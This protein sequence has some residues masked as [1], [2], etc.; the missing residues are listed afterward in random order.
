MQAPAF[1][2]RTCAEGFSAQHEVIPQYQEFVTQQ[3]AEFSVQ[4]CAEVPSQPEFS[5][6][7]C[8]EISS[9]REPP[10]A[11]LLFAEFGRFDLLGKADL[12][13]A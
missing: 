6:Q 11:L 9:H 12:P 5:L 13:V 1:S 4:Q 8:A 10:L 7:Q 2:R 3:R